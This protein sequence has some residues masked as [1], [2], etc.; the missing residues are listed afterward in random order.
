MNL[1]AEAFISDDQQTFKRNLLIICWIIHWYRYVYGNHTIHIYEYK[2]KYKWWHD[3][4]KNIQFFAN[5][6]YF[7]ILT[8]IPFERWTLRT[9]IYF[10]HSQNQFPLY[11]HTHTPF[12]QLNILFLHAYSRSSSSFS[13]IHL[14]STWTVR[15]LFFSSVCI[16]V[17]SC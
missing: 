5:E 1:L 11:T 7:Y 14:L 2:Y 13:I 3:Y 12:T 10:S 15:G 8:N 6:K 4:W 9:L 16:C 17:C